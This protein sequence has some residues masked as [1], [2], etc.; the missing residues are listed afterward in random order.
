MK[1]RIWHEII[2]VIN[3]QIYSHVEQGYE[4][5]HTTE[6]TMTILNLIFDYFIPIHLKKQ[7]RKYHK[8]ILLVFIHMLLLT[9]ITSSLIVNFV[10]NLDSDLIYIPSFFLLT[11]SITIFK[12]WGN[13]ILS[14]NLLAIATALVLGYLSLTTGG[15][16]SLDY[17]FM[18]IIPLLAYI[19]SNKKSG[20]VWFALLFLYSVFLLILEKTTYFLNQ[21]VDNVPIQSF[22]E[23]IHDDAI[24]YF[25]TPNLLF[26]FI[27]L[28]ISFLQK[29]Q[30]DTIND[31]E[32][33]TQKLEEKKHELEQQKATLE[34]Q[35]ATLEKQKLELQHQ[36]IALRKS[37]DELELYARITSHD[38]KQPLR[39]ITSF[40]QLLDRHMEKEN[41]IDP[42]VTEYLEYITSSS[43][44]MNKLIDDLRT[45]GRLENDANNKFARADFNE[46]M[47]IVSKNL[48]FFIRK[49]NVIINYE[50]LPTN[51]YITQSKITQVLQ[52]II[53]NAIKFR[54]IN[55]RCS[56]VITAKEYN[57]Y[58][59]F[60]ISDNGIGIQE[61]YFHKIFEVFR[62]LHSPTEYQGT[63]MGLSICK[64][65]IEQHDGK[66]WL[67]STYGTGTT[68]YFTISKNLQS[69]NK[70]HKDKEL[71]YSKIIKQEQV[72]NYTN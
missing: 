8:A 27:L 66:I 57:D 60:A 2:I 63:G 14:G 6:M 22:Q 15:I 12:K 37:N 64:K 65:I 59:R 71:D 38:F 53:A 33:Q 29:K 19:L 11:L 45:Y 20:L 54:H 36:E 68:F 17:V 30:E 41:L 23:M 26:Y 16:Y 4:F 34:E 61:E 21:K 24:Y 31:L 50:N 35:K 3:S 13:F 55:R 62:K 40:S 10:F 39:S 9:I 46:L 49:N 56:L 67:E 32:K 18:I 7:V 72:T 70:Q 25:I 69:L 48:S 47:N 28:A 5:H 43:T 58:W 42:T 52:N 1:N 51:I 44:H